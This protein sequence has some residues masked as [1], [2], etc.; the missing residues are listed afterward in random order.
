LKTKALYFILIL[1]SGIVYGQKLIPLEIDGPID[2]LGSDGEYLYLS[3]NESIIQLTPDTY[4]E[5]QSFSLPGIVKYDYLDCSQ[6]LKIFAFSEYAQQY[7]LL[8]QFLNSTGSKRL[9]DLNV[10]YGQLVTPSSDGSV[11]ILDQPTQTLRKIDPIRALQYIS[12]PLEQ[13]YRGDASTL[14]LVREVSNRLFMLAVK[15]GILQL[16]LYGNALGKISHEKVNW[17]TVNASSVYYTSGRSLGIK[18][19]SDSSFSS[20]PLSLAP[21]QFTVIGRKAILTDGKD[22]YELDLD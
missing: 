4:R 16:D 1:I 12:V 17:F 22:L 15:D 19:L 7:V 13:F 5:R 9:I 21:T 20:I 6:P 3:S 11:W 18:N 2:A 14:N 10:A 8:D